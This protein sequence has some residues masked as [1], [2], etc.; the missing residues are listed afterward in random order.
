MKWRSLF[1][2]DNVAKLIIA[3]FIGLAF[4]LLIWPYGMEDE[5]VFEVA[6]PSQV[7]MFEDSS[8]SRHADVVEASISGYLDGTATVEIYYPD[9]IHRVWTFELSAGR[10]DSSGRWD[11]YDREVRIDYVPGTAKK[12]HLTIKTKVF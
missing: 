11:F 12:G 5:R 10:I 3:F 9:T 4:F 2:A 7:Y 1:N 6:D 8:R